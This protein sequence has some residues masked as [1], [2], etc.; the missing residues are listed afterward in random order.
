MKHHEVLYES[1]KHKVFIPETI[2]VLT[3][4]LCILVEKCPSHKQKLV[5]DTLNYGI[6]MSNNNMETKEQMRY[7][8]DKIVPSMINC[9]VSLDKDLIRINSRKW[10]Y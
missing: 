10:W 9:F 3:L 6:I 4:E 1:L 5:I 2:V 7:L 8:V